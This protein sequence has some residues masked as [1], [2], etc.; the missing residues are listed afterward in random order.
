[1]GPMTQSSSPQP[2]APQPV[3]LLRDIGA[4]EIVPGTSAD[5]AS[6]DAFVRAHPQGTFFHLSGW[7]RVVE[8]VMG[9]D[10]C[11][12]IARSGDR[13]IGVLPLMRAPSL[14]TRRALISM[15][16]AVY[17]GP[18]GETPEIEAALVRAAVVQ[19]QRERVGR[20]EL[21]CRQAPAK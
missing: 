1:M 19:A 15:P 17:G 14:I 16:F 2:S 6:R 5:D 20:L 10:S 21:R 8:S 12:W 9:H 4:W 11:D 3:P 18:L 13:I 7:R